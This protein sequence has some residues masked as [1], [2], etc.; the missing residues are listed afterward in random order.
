MK[1]SCHRKS[2]YSTPS[3]GYAGSDFGDLESFPSPT[4]P[5]GGGGGG[6]GV[7]GG[8][9]VHPAAAAASASSSVDAGTQSALHSSAQH[10]LTAVA[11]AAAVTYPQS[12]LAYQVQ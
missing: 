12:A 5:G 11:A 1:S 9:G 10:P 4:E 8:S 6:G 3:G 2:P 7:G